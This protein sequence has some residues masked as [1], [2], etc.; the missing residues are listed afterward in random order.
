MV[1]LINDFSPVKVVVSSL[2]WRGAPSRSTRKHLGGHGLM[3]ILGTRLS[4]YVDFWVPMICG[5]RLSWHDKA[6]AFGHL[7][8]DEGR[9]AQL[10]ASTFT[11]SHSCPLIHTFS[12]LTC[13]E[14]A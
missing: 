5:G 11:F 10:V 9:S 6:L 4:D 8:L 7:V 2:V 1:A 3:I 13:L 12:N 14:C